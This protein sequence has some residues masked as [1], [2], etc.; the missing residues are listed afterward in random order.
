M[1]AFWSSVA[2]MSG[3]HH[4]RPLQKHARFPLEASHFDRWLEL[5]RATAHEIGSP[6]A[7]VSLIEKAERI[8]LSLGSGIGAVTPRRSSA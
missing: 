7:A 2:L 5:V 6:E 4:G 3:R 8:A 1:V